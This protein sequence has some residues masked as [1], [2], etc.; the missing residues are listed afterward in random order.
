M[1][2]VEEVGNKKFELEVVVRL[3]LFEAME[4]LEIMV[5]V[6][7]IGPAGCGLQGKEL[8][9][10][11]GGGSVPYAVVVLPAEVVLVLP[12]GFLGRQ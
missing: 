11:G 6:A 12:V 3:L 5:L 2:E 8:Q 10:D 1:T 4:E 7:G 9:D